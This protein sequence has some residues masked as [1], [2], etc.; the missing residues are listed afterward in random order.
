MDFLESI[1]HPSSKSNLVWVALANIGIQSMLMYFVVNFMFA[2][3]GTASF[4]RCFLCVIGLTAVLAGSFFAAGFIP[5]PYLNLIVAIVLWWKLSEAVIGS[6]F[7]LVE[8]ATTVLIL[9]LIV[10]IGL[11]WGLQRLL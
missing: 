9:Y 5:I 11:Y 10:S 4:V 1:F 6:A 3:R 8:G 2:A 7:E